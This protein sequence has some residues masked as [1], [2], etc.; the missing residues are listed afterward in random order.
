MG[1]PPKS[2][3]VGPWGGNGGTSWD[4]G[5]FPGIR[6]ITLVSGLCIDSIVVVYD[7][8][9]QPFK[10]QKHGGGEGDDTA[11]ASLIFVTFCFTLS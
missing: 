4:D 10:A 5:I 9:G 2:L 6:K 3:L 7:M 8:H 1:W 11:E